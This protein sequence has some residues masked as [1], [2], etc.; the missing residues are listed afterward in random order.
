MNVAFFERNKKLFIAFWFFRNKLRFSNLLIKFFRK[1]WC[2]SFVFYVRYWN[3][4]DSQWRKLS[5]RK[6]FRY[7]MWKNEKLTKCLTNNEIAKSKKT[8]IKSCESQSKKCW[9]QKNFHCDSSFI[10]RSIIRKHTHTQFNT[11]NNLIFMNAQRK[12]ISQQSQQ[13]LFRINLIAIFK[14][15]FVYWKQCLKKNV[16]QKLKKKLTK[17]K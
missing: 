16:Q 9:S 13:H 10:E 4:D 3:F 15:L 5:N 17:R 14:K 6:L 2:D 11:I 1:N 12:I 7:V 8:S